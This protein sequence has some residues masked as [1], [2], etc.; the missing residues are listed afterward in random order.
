MHTGAHK[1]PVFP[2]LLALGSTRTVL[3]KGDITRPES[4]AVHTL[5]PL[6]REE[7]E[8]L[9]SRYFEVFGIKGSEQEK[10]TVTNCLHAWSDGWPSHMHNAL[11][12]LSK[13]LLQ[14]RADI[15]KVTLEQSLEKA[16]DYR[17]EYYSDRLG[18]IFETSQIFL[19]QFMSAFPASGPI[20]GKDILPLIMD[21]QK[22]AISLGDQKMAKHSAV[23]VFDRLLHQG[24]I[25][26]DREKNYI[27][28]IP[29]LRRWCLKQARMEDPQE[30][31]E[32][33]PKS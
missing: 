24:F 29:S 16:K 4:G 8:E 20:M 23:Y 31:L 32:T 28:P 5:P 14:V 26:P 18:E 27:C 7:V 19:G 2:L 10:K 17:Q 6:T 13:E 15:G 3:V 1:L 9:C 12:G 30:T 11:K 21:T 22:K 25:Q 33:E